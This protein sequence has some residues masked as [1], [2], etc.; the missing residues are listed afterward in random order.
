MDKSK[1]KCAPEN[2]VLSDTERWK[3]IDRHLS[4]IHI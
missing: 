1:E 2:M 4:L 3:N